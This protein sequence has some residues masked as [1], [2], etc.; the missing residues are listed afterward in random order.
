M[1]LRRTLFWLFEF[2]AVPGTIWV[3]ALGFTLYAAWLDWRTR[4]IPN[5]L[6]VSGV[7]AGVALNSIVGRWHGAMLSLEGAGLALLVLL[8]LVLLRGMGAGDWKLMGAVGA[9]MGWRPMLFVLLVSLLTSGL[10]AIVQ[11]IATKRVKRTL[12][13]IV[14]L[15]KGLATFGLRLDPT[16]SLDNP[17]LLKVPFGVATGAA[18]VLSFA[19][20]HWR[21]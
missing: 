13:N 21:Q 16:I 12:W 7:V 4:R 2:Y 17:T 5:R 8:P 20:T 1:D 15:V 18:T 3:V 11:M 10:M 19:L 9:M 14:L 6:T